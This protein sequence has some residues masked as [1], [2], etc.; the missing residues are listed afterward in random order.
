MEKVIT[1]QYG[2]RK[3]S[4]KSERPLLSRAFSR[5]NFIQDTIVV[6]LKAKFLAFALFL[7]FF[8]ENGTLGLV[9][10]KYYIIYRSVRI[11]DLIQYALIIY[12]FFCIK[13]YIDLFKSRALLLAKLVLLYFMF[14]FVVSAAAYKFN[15]IEYFFRLKGV[16]SSF[17]LF[18][19]LLLLKR[20]GLGFLIKIIFPVAVISNILYLM[21]AVTGTAFLPDV[22][23][24]LQ[25]LPGGIEVYRVYGGTFF[26]DVFFLGFIYQW[27]EKRF[28]LYQLFFT[29]L[30]IIPQVL[31]FS[32]GAWV[33]FVFIILFLVFMNSWKKRNFKILFRQAVILILLLCALVFSFIY[34]MPRSDFYVDALNARILQGQDD[35][36]FNEGTYGERGV[37]SNVLVK[38]WLE[39]NPLIGIGMHPMWVYR[40]ESLEE[41][42]Y[43]NA[44]SDV[45]WPSVLAAYGAIGF[46]IAVIFQIYYIKKTYK[47]IM[48][49][50]TSTV[51]IFLLTTLLAKMVFDSTLGFSHGLFSVGLWGLAG[52]MNFTIANLIFC[53]EEQ[54]L[55][56]DSGNLKNEIPAKTYGLYGKYYSSSYKM[57]KLRD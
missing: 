5:E 18:P 17:L 28:R 42:R 27:L 22:Y 31:A 33:N 50:K 45:G 38:L 4:G 48:K 9:P 12:S 40:P 47:V 2:F 30:F 41:Q 19:Y 35:V 13:E 11:S 6:S 20:N 1:N 51:Y 23:I 16:W 26:G 46:I 49:S 24:T 39:N 43:Y 54:K 56:S 57:Y 29:I 3:N 10:E 44:F 15:I 55:Q 32:R 14:E 8:F 36:Q 53:Y 25:K 21:T 37:Q 34:F 7:Y 52:T